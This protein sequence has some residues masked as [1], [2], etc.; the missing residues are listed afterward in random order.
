MK[1]REILGPT[2]KS[3]N[4]DVGKEIETFVNVHTISLCILCS[5]IPHKLTML[6]AHSVVPQNDQNP[7][8]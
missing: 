3:K 8:F 2:E 7:Q 5:Q 6:P 1:S 4:F